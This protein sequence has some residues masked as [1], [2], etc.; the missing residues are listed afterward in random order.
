MNKPI[1]Y[2]YCSKCDIIERKDA[3]EIGERCACAWYEK[4]SL[5]RV[6]CGRPL[7]AVA[8]YPWGTERAKA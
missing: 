1:V 8:L 6:V 4:H 2:R 5:N 7:M 3:S